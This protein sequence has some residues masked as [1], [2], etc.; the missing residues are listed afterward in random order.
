MN[1]EKKEKNIEEYNCN[2][3][4]RIFSEEYYRKHDKDYVSTRFIGYEMKGLKVLLAKYDVWSILCA[5]RNCIKVNTKTVTVHYVISSPKEYLPD[6]NAE[7]Q[8]MVSEYG[9]P[10]MKTKWRELLLST[11][12][13]FPSATQNKRQKVLLQELQGWVYEKEKQQGWVG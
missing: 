5:I 4:H 6:S 2:D 7:I 3:L 9:T 10:E 13:W 1:M 12:Q 11:S 8:W